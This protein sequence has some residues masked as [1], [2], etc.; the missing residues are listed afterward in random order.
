MKFK[1]WQASRGLPPDPFTEWLKDKSSQFP[2]LFTTDPAQ[3]R[4][5]PLAVTLN[6]DIQYLAARVR[7]LHMAA[8]ANDCPDAEALRHEVDQALR[9][10]ADSI[11]NFTQGEVIRL[12]V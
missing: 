6:Q 10:I 8:K 2:E 9:L 12:P 4:Y 11:V 5:E 1:D 3:F 7:A